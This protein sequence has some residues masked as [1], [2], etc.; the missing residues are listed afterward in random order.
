M[1]LW[2]PI[3]LQMSLLIN[4]YSKENCDNCKLE[5]QF[6]TLIYLSLFCISQGE[7]PALWEVLQC[8][9]SCADLQFRITFLLQNHGS[10]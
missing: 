9:K 5:T 4:S 6:C 7:I 1:C 3:Y 10:G 2:F 8:R